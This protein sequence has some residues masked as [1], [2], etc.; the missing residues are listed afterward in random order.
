MIRDLSMSDTM[1]R[2]SIAAR[3]TT[4]S[5]VSSCS[6]NAASSTLLRTND[7]ES[8]ISMSEV[9]KPCRARRSMSREAVCSETWNSAGSASARG[10]QDTTNGFDAL[11]RSSG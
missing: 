3:V 6:A 5:S 10:H 7:T 11:L 2:T 8:S 1:E 4:E 9:E